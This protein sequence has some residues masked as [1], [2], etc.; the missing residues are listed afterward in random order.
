MV[1]EKDL[2]QQMRTG[3]RR[4]ASGV[5]VVTGR[6]DEDN[7]LAMTASSITSVSDSPAS[8][9]VCIHNDSYLSAAIN[10]TGLFCINLLANEHQDISIRCASTE[11]ELDR[12][13]IGDWV[14]DADSGIYVLRDAQA[15]FYCEKTA[16]LEYGT[17]FI[18]VGNI[19]SVQLGSEEINPLIYLDG[20]YVKVAE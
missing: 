11:E 7:R 2:A 1:D 10:A 9:L 8:L 14:L 5:S 19:L 6:D 18:F 20:K 13:A 12:F 15:I 16:E 3:M 17:H 4:L